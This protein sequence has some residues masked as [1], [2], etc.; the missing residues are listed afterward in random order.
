MA[1]GGALVDKGWTISR[2]KTEEKVDG[3]RKFGAPSK[4]KRFR[5]RLDMVAGS[6]QNTEGRWRRIIRPTL[7]VGRK[8]TLKANDEVEVKS[9][10][11]LKHLGE[12]IIKFKV[13]GDPL[14]IRK[15]RTTI[16]YVYTLV[17][18]R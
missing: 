13:V 4:G 10:E 9:K 12:E 11:A 8:S 1:L 2:T 6:E 17:Q 16:G 3:E 18:V 14:P 15:R 7:V 5:C